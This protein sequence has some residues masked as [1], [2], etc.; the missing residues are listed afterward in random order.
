ML[1]LAQAVWVQVGGVSRAAVLL[2]VLLLLLQ[3]GVVGTA[4]DSAS[5]TLHVTDDVATAY[6]RSFG[7]MRTMRDKESRRVTSELLL[8]MSR[9]ARCNPASGSWHRRPATRVLTVTLPVVAEYSPVM[10]VGVQCSN[11]AAGWTADDDEVTGTR[12]NHVS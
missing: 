7:R 3:A 1:R 12:I 5:G 4:R 10:S 11:S 9:A 2:A 8:I 6:K